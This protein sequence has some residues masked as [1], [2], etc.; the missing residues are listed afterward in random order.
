MTERHI[1][2]CHAKKGVIVGVHSHC[3][4]PA[5]SPVRAASPIHPSHQ[6]WIIGD[7]VVRTNARNRPILLIDLTIC[8]GL[9]AGLADAEHP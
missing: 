7:E 6:L 5:A 4:V 2:I 1:R 8:N 9:L 3:L